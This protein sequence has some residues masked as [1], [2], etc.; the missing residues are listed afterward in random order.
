MLNFLIFLIGIS[1]TA[2]RISKPH[3]LRTVA[4]ENAILKQ[5]LLVLRR[6]YR[7]AP[8]TKPMDRLILGLLCCF[9]PR[10]RINKI[11]VVFKPATLLKFHR[12]LVKRKYRLLFASERS[13]KKAGRKPLAPELVKLIL[14]I[15]QKNP[16]FGYA[17]IALQIRQAFGTDISPEAVG[18]ILRNRQKPP[19][20]GGDGPSWLTF[21]KH[22]KDSLWSLDFFRC[23]SMTLQS[24]WVIVAMD[25]FT[26]QIVGFAVHRSHLNGP[27]ICRMFNG[28]LKQA[29]TTPRFLSTDNDPLFKFHRWQANLNIL[30]IS[31]LKSTP[32][33]PNSHPFIERLIG[34]C[35]RELLDHT[36]FWNERDLQNKLDQFKG[37]YNRERAHMGI[38]GLTPTQMG[39][40]SKTVKKRAEIVG[41]F[42]QSHCRGLFQLPVAR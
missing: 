24:H 12:Q 34:T 17:R 14:D 13:R 15:K 23:E 3:G 20:T 7:G 35:R 38:D 42:W 11:A 25:Q 31:E 26:R 2:C 22:S 28:I 40:P 6:R 36:L 30:D 39:N 5:Q 33:N 27:D 9:I 29:G 8:K 16:H 1:Q 41:Y 32:Y 21:F 18:R 19:L 4:T 10:K 37:F